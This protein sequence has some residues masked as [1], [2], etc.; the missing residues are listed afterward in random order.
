MDA[1]CTMLLCLKFHQ[2]QGKLQP[3]KIWEKPAILWRNSMCI[4]SIEKR[5]L[6]LKTPDFCFPSEEKKKDYIFF[7]ISALHA[8][9]I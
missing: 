2:K 7:I 8:P 9:A 4:H 3:V 5:L 6:S 1:F